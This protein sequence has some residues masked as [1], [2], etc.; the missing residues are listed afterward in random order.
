MLL[1]C[2]SW[3]PMRWAIL[4]PSPVFI[5]PARECRYGICRKLPIIDWSASKPPV[6]RT[7][8]PLALT[9]TSAPSFSMTQPTTAPVSSVMR[10]LPGVP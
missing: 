6:A 10:R 1:M 5:Q 4:M 9:L 2:H 8:P 3:A 7:T